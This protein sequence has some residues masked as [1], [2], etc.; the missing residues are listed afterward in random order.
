MHRLFLSSL[1][2]K[3]LDKIDKEYQKSIY[4]S[5]LDIGENPYLGKRLKGEHKGKYSLRVGKYRIIYEIYKDDFQ[6][7]VLRISHRKEAYR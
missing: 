1:A 6:V 4:E 5:L 3:S 7:L 2:R